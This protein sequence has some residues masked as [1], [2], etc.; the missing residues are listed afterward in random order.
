MVALTQYTDTFNAPS[1]M[2][3]L[4]PTLLTAVV[5]LECIGQCPHEELPALK[6]QL[7]GDG[8]NDTTREMVI[9]VCVD[10]YQVFL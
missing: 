8:T 6:C 2:N 3:Y 4:S 7:C 5:T 9:T 1:L 10:L